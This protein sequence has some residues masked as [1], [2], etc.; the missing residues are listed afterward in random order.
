MCED[1]HLRRTPAQ[2]AK[3]NALLDTDCIPTP[4]HKG[5]RETQTASGI[6]LRVASVLGKTLGTPCRTCSM[7]LHQTFA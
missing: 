7:G 3:L 1:L 2:Q 4:R 6:R 5:G